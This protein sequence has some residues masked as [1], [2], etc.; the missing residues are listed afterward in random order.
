MSIK[1]YLL[2]TLILAALHTAAIGQDVSAHKT[3]VF[4][5]DD[6]ASYKYNASSLSG[7]CKIVDASGKD[8]FPI[9]NASL[10]G[11][12]RV[13][14]Y[15]AR[16]WT[17]KKWSAPT[18]VAG[19]RQIPALAGGSFE[20]GGLRITFQQT[21]GDSYYTLDKVPD[22]ADGVF[23]FPVRANRQKYNAVQI[24]CSSSCKITKITLAFPS[25]DSFKKEWGLVANKFGGFD[26]Y[27]PAIRESS[28][29]KEIVPASPSFGDTYW[30]YTTA[31]INN[32][33]KSI[34]IEY[35]QDPTLTRQHSEKKDSFEFDFAALAAISHPRLMM[36]DAD[37]RDVRKALSRMD[38]NV[39]TMHEAIMAQAE[40]MN[41]EKKAFQYEPD[42]IK[43]ALSVSR[44]FLKCAIACGYA[45][46]FTKDKSYVRMTE[47]VVEYLC[48]NYPEWIEKAPIK[49]FIVEAE[50]ALGLA[51]VYD[52]MFKALKPEMKDLIRKEIDLRMLKHKW[53]ESQGNNRSQVCNAAWFACAA[54]V[55]E[56]LDAGKMPPLIHE[57]VEDLRETMNIIYYPDGAANESPSYWAY[58][59]N[60][61]AFA[62]WV[63]NSAYGTDFG[64]RDA[65]GFEKTLDYYIFSISNI[66]KY[67]TYGDCNRA[68]AASPCMWYYAW[69]FDKPG[70]LDAEIKLLQKGMYKTQRAILLGI[71]PAAKL[72]KIK[73]SVPDKKSYIAGGTAPVYVARTGWNKDDAFLGIKGGSPSST[74]H[75]HV[76]EGAFIYDAFGVRW[77]DDLP[78]PS[79]QLTRNAVSAAKSTVSPI[80]KEH[81]AW[82][83]F[84]V[85]NRQHNTLTINSHNQ[86]PDGF[87]EL[88]EIIAPAGKDFG[89]K[90][91]LSQMYICD[92][93]NCSRSAIL[94]PDQS[95]D[96]RDSFT[97]WEDADSAAEVRWTLCTPVKPVIKDDRIVLNS[98]GVKMVIKTDAPE[99]VFQEWPCD[100]T[101]YNDSPTGRHEPADA[102]K[103][104]YLCGF[105][106]K[107]PAGSIQDFTTTFRRE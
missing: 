89:C 23:L 14:S 1:K 9:I 25:D 66:G 72:G 22:S 29:I 96:I 33:F 28:G 71:V 90:V 3:V 67:F 5:A 61:Q 7:H 88:S 84:H 49:A 41:L 16:T 94:H 83:V 8:I 104:F 30:L 46:R 60:F 39:T 64:L 45:Y 54:A 87:A 40:D 100:P 11:G 2:G 6:A 36:S 70:Y 47:T 95:L 65:P 85:S 99:A 17:G 51:V 81:A 75:A 97:V 4:S 13:Y 57:R 76:D 15:R 53:K 91:D 35:E 27:T 68:V 20:K 19:A 102:Y 63:L 48:A 82:Y 93:K 34:T 18:N 12:E 62:L 69:L 56:T 26:D 52:W 107:A 105:T 77:A 44:E 74:G 50:Y 101:A 106:F 31:S 79:Y 59:A 103:G 55:A 98:K 86:M 38:P 24:S 80:N 58:G 21:S 73:T 10:S 32:A 43:D 92:L 78:H 37:L 42:G